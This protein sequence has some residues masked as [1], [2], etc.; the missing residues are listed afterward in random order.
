[1]AE[2]PVQQK[3]LRTIVDVMETPGPPRRN[4]GG[5][6]RKVTVPDVAPDDLD[7][8]V[9]LRMIAGSSAVPPAV[10]AAACRTLLLL[11]PRTD[12]GAAEPRPPADALTSRALQILQ[13]RPN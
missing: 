8:I 1:V 4:R 5:R 2:K 3:G 6:P 9:V 10:R 11:T 13:R 7:P 12:A